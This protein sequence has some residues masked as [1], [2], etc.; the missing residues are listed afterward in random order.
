MYI[1]YTLLRIFND[2]LYFRCLK[3]HHSG[4]ESR[5]FYSKEFFYYLILN[6]INN[7][8]TKFELAIHFLDSSS[9]YRR[10]LPD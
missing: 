8:I 3:T 4:N 1:K 6:Y 9:L 10:I 2:N 7:K 5:R